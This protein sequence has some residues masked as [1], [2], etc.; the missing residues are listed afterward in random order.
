MPLC[1]PCRAEAEYTRNGR[2]IG[3]ERP[4][5]EYPPYGLSWGDSCDRCGNA[6]EVTL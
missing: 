6:A 2:A 1:S 5:E 3:G 4:A